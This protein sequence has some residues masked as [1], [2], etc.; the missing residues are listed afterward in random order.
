M[1]EFLQDEFLGEQPDRWNIAAEQVVLGC[2]LTKPDKIDLLPV[3]LKADDFSRRNRPVF[4]AAIDLFSQGKA[5][6]V[7]TVAEHLGSDQL[8]Y[9]CDLANSS[10]SYA[11]LASYAKIILN[12]SLNRKIEEIGKELGELSY[13]D[14]DPDEKIGVVN[15]KIS[16]LEATSAEEDGTDLNTVLKSV[17]NSIDNRFHGKE[18]PGLS[19][20]FKDLDEKIIG[21]NPGELVVVAGRPSMGKTTFGMNI[22]RHNI[23]QDKNVLVYSIETTKEKLM[24]RMLSDVGKIPLMKI[25]TGQ[26]GEQDWPNLEC[27]AR[28]LKDK[29]LI[30][31]DLSNLHIDRAQA[32]ARKINRKKK[33][34]LVVVDYLQLMRGEGENETLRLAE[35]SRGLRAMAKQINVPVIAV[36][37][38]NRGTEKST[39]RR[40][41]IADIR[42]SGQIE[43]DAD[44]ILM[45]YRDE[46]YNEDSVEKGIAEII[47]G[48]QKNGETGTI[49]VASKLQHNSFEDLE[50]YKPPEPP[51]KPYSPYAKK[52]KSL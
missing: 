45:I 11:N 44:V 29:S 28:R 26:L 2:M 32:I 40:P 42:Q 8:D 4:Q 22:V 17:I 51:Q 3:Q 18:L 14:V 49:R 36:A 20:G 1:M 6:D 47:I 50:G 25:R 10:A 16:G 31:S 43:Q 52:K 33:L 9:I 35:V 15:S 24:E 48:K 5:V 39:N 19:T 41:T 21:L 12:H 27:A 30:L 34:D 23:L 13:A 7:I 37:Q 46:Y 38:I